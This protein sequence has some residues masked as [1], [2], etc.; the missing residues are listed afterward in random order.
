MYDW[1]QGFLCHFSRK[2]PATRHRQSSDLKKPNLNYG[3]VFLSCFSKALYVIFY[4]LKILL[5]D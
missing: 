1:V 4:V 5:S 2:P 3:T